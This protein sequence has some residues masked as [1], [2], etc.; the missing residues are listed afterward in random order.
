MQMCVCVCEVLKL[1]FIIFINSTEKIRSPFQ[2]VN[3]CLKNDEFVCGDFPLSI[4][5]DNTHAYTH[6]SDEVLPKCLQ[7]KN[8]YI[9]CVTSLW[10]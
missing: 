9:V 4:L 6:T 1:F 7:E 2:Y 8:K 3:Y 5:M 10:G